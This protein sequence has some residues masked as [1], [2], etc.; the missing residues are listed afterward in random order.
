MKKNYSL[1]FFFTVLISL[2]GFAQNNNGSVSGKISDP[3]TGEMID[4]AGVAI[5]MQG[6][7]DII[8]SNT[9]SN[10]GIFKLTGLPYGKY[11]LRISYIGFE[12]QV[13]DDIE[14]T[15]EHPDAYLGIIK[16]KK[17]SSSLNEVTISEKKAAVEFGADQITYNVSQSLQSEGSTATDI[18]KNVPMVNV[19]INGNAT[20]AGKRSTRIFIDGKP[21]DYMTSNIADLLN[22]LPSEAIE[23]IEV[24]TNPPVK[25]SADGEGIINIVLKKGYKVGL[26]GTLSLNGGTL[27]NYNIN[28]YVAYR[29]K[30]LSLTSSYAFGESER[31]STGS[32]LS[33]NFLADTNYYR[34]QYSSNN[35]LNFGHNIRESVNWDI[36]TTQNLRLTTNFNIN[37][38]NGASASDYYYLD[39][40]NIETSL[41]NQNNNNHNHSFN[42]VFDADYT[43]KIPGGDQL[44]ASATYSGN[45]ANTDRLAQSY[46]LDANGLP[47]NGI[48]PLNQTYGVYAAGRALQVKVDY[49]KP[50]GKSKNTADFG[51]SANIRTSDNNQVVQDFNFANQM[52]LQ[53]LQLTNQFIYN[54]H[55]YGGYASL[56]IRTQKKWS[57]RIGGRSELTDINFNVSSLPDQYHIKP[58]INLFPNLSINK[59]FSNYTIGIS[60]SGRIVRPSPNSLNPQVITNASNPN[61]S[62][63]NPNLAPAYTQQVDFSFS[64]FGKNW[65]FYPRIGI[66]NTSHIIERITTPISSLAYQSTYDNLGTSSYNTINLYGNY[67]VAK[68]INV[69]GG[70]T[71]GRIAYHSNNNSALNRNGITFQSKAGIQIDMPKQLAFESNLNYYTNSSAQGR[72]KGSLSS[73]FAIRKSVYKNKVRIRLTAI[74]P[75][76][77]GSSTTFTQGQTFNR[78][79]YYM[80]NNRNYSLSVSYNFTKV[81]RNTAS[82]KQKKDV[83]PPEVSL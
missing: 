55:I 52:Y 19:D 33:D 22:V 57:F 32:S 68:K 41:R 75:T 30:S 63:G 27:G 46:T 62:F 64:L 17:N 69:S 1:I 2:K 31:S 73:S 54:E 50:L 67:H 45:S 36:D 42:Y 37:K 49:D 74:N 15:A 20:I 78:Q 59:T 79:D 26:N 29:T 77:Q 28:S 66:A 3:T 43:W 6:S 23:K 56:S 38:S 8:R 83:P 35:G 5:F 18:L 80:Q 81:G 10:G 34:N 7:D 12:K 39:E 61:I 48:L 21:S 44:E 71:V 70:A 65:A 16:L 13:V 47:I 51:L 11:G 40:N 82:K 25:Y 58:Y 72:S 76:G 14:I 60:Y 53:D 24:M 9:S 4:F